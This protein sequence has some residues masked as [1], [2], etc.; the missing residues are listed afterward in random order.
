MYVIH[1]SMIDQFIVSQVTAGTTNVKDLTLADLLASDRL[2]TMFE[3]AYALV[4]EDCTLREAK[5]AMCAVPDCRD[6]FVTAT[7]SKDE[8]VLGWLTNVD[9]EGGTATS[10][11]A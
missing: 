9:L 6:I 2:R 4:S 10:T 5:A 11:I 7:G 8:P 3:N 1:R